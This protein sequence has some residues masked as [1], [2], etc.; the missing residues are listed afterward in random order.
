MQDLSTSAT[1]P[2]AE[3]CGVSDD[4]GD[5]YDL[6]K[7]ALTDWARAYLEEHPQYVQWRRDLLEKGEC[8]VEWRS[9][10][11]YLPRGHDGQHQC[12]PPGDVCCYPEPD[13]EL[14]G[15]DA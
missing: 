1:E 8:R 7:G 6:S 5:I 12:G 2:P 11:C 10:G 15:E 4:Y 13:D 9:H 3:G 14:V